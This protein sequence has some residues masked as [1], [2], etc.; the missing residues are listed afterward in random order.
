MEQLERLIAR[1]ILSRVWIHVLFCVV[2][3]LVFAVSV[4]LSGNK[5]VASAAMLTCLFVLSCTY[6][7]RWC[8]KYWLKTGVHASFLQKLLLSILIFSLTGA[9]GGSYLYRGELFQYFVQYFTVSFPMVILF[10]FFGIAIALARNSLYR[11]INEAQVL[12]K[13]KESEMRLLLSQLSPHFLFN[14]LNNIYG[15]SLT[16]HQRVPSL[17]LKLSELLRYSVY[18]TRAQFISL[19]DELLYIRNYIDFE[20]I[21]TGDRVHLH[22]D[23]PEVIDLNLRIAPM[24][25]IVFVENAFKYSK[26]TKDPKSFISIR[27]NVKGDWIYFEVENSYDPAYRQETEPSESSGIGLHHTLKRLKL[28]YGNDCLYNNFAENGKYRIE[29]CLKA[30]N[31]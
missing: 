6:A 11:Q 26:I 19:Q 12:Q 17:L 2:F 1:L 3:V 31:K 13:Q 8:G 16:Q 9:A 14:T 24:L 18:E 22:I 10:I 25:L 29:L 5:G 23:I 30:S 28:I 7:G 4:V 20:K 27:L 15:I 21:Q